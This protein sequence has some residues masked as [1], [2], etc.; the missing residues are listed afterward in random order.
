MFCSVLLIA[1]IIITLQALENPRYY[2]DITGDYGTVSISQDNNVL[3]ITWREPF[4]SRPDA[5]GKYNELTGKGFVDFPDDRLFY[6][7]YNAFE[8]TINWTSADNSITALW[9]KIAVAGEY[10][11]TFGTN[12][13]I[14]GIDQV[15]GVDGCWDINVEFEASAGRQLASG[16]YCKPDGDN[17]YATGDINFP[18]HRLF[19][20]YYYYDSEILYFD[21]PRS[22]SNTFWE[23]VH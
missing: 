22:S 6:F 18:D 8:D 7:E 4:V 3:A 11:D 1:S 5:F 15:A 20:I 16:N 19:T 10:T 14:Y 9:N 13:E 23:K 2:N 12:I 17:D 21:G